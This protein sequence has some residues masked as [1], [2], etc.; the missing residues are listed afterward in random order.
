MISSQPRPSASRPSTSDLKPRSAIHDASELLRL[1]S[2]PDRLKILLS[3]G[4]EERNV[5]DLVK[6]S[7]GLSAQYV[8]R[9]IGH[10][11][12]GGLVEDRIA[13]AFRI[14]ALTEVGKGLLRAIGKMSG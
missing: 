9:H 1:A 13:G 14:Y 7:P 8:S 11:R 6:G 3:L 10:L 5:S 2:N 12:R 4:R